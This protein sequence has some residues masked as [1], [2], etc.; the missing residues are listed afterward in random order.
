MSIKLDIHAYM[1]ALIA[2]IDLAM[3]RYLTADDEVPP[4]LLEAMRYSVYAGGKRLR[5]ILALA[6]AEALGGER[7]AALPAA[8]ALEFIHTYSL[9]HDDL[10]AMDNDDYRRG[11]LTNHRVYGE[12]GAVLAGDALQALAFRALSDSPLPAGRVVQM[13][14]ELARASG[15]AGMVGGQ[16]A[17]IE[18][19]GKD[20]TPDSLSYIHRHKTG[21]LITAAVRLGAI[22]QGADADT[23]AQL[24]VYAE[25]IG[26][27]FQIMDDLLDSA[28]T[29]ANA[30]K[31]TYPA[32]FG[33][34]QSQAL[35]SELTEQAKS[36][37]LSAGGVQNRNMLMAVAD[38]LSSRDH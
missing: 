34:P 30:G 20:A 28:G 15:P 32:L 1:N 24:T 8:C 26:L 35:V 4:Q 13:V 27:A 6:V 25:C 22:A 38:Y 14:L 3:D 33:V 19:E 36:A 29:D 31:A 9:I 17:D 23:L 5:P 11:K 21:A 12:A 10:P 37:L 18:H 16:S 7:A 2:E